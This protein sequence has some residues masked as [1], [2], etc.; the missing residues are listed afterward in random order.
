MTLFQDAPG[1]PRTAAAQ[2]A[3]VLALYGAI[4]DA[5]CGNPSGFA[6]RK[7]SAAVSLARTAQLES[8]ECDAIFFAG[9]LHAIGAIGS[10]AFRKGE[11]LSPRA[12]R[13]ESW[14]VPALGARACAQIGAL[15][16]ATADIV[17]WQAECWDGTGYPDLL[18]WHGIPRS[19]MILALA[20]GFVRAGDPEEALMN[21]GEQSGR[22]FN[23][24]L[25]N[26]FTMWYHAGGGE[27]PLAEPPLQSLQHPAR[28]ETE[29]LLESIADQVDAH[30]AV[31]GRWRRVERLT[32]ACATI[33]DLDTQTSRQLALAVR[34]YGAGEIGDPDP[35]GFDP[36]ARLG[37]E[38]RATHALAAAALVDD[39]SAFSSVA[40]LL[41]A[42]SEWYDGTGKPGGLLHQ[43][44]PAGARVLAAA[45]AY[46]SLDRKDRIGDAIGT[47]FE[48]RAVAA[49]TQAAEALA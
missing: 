18:R 38:Q 2:F 21:V 22:A 17:R 26:V 23:P 42:R 37:I 11:R 29:R 14:D 27:V 32:A 35:E 20:D 31:Q 19:A 34:M 46:D 24:D 30:N 9:I 16:A 10:P 3:D 6:L 13:M 1:D 25:A 48:P 15:P 41:R 49:I 28:D 45:I 43:A 7:A 4:G 39:T 5:A 44:I 33:L 8:P 36:L 40:E 47:Q 12:A